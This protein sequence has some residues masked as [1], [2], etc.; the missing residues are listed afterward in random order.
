LC[1]H[2]AFVAFEHPLTGKRVEVDSAMPEDMR[3]FW[4]LA[5]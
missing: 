3:E 2:A 4:D 5:P 1:L